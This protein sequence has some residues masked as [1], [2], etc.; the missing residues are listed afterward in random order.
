MLSPSPS[1]AFPQLFIL[2]RPCL[3]RQFLALDFRLCWG[4][5]AVFAFASELKQE[6]LKN[7]L[8][9]GGRL[10]VLISIEINT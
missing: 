4:Q 7:R 1:S 6:E 9:I 8:N 10:S 3:T 5:F 2:V